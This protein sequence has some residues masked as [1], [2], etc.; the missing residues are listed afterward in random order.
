MSTD[1]PVVDDLD[2]RLAKIRAAGDAP[3]IPVPSIWNP[4]Y[5]L[6]PYQRAGA[7]HLAV[8]KRFVL[9]DPTGSGKTPQELYAW[10]LIRDLRIKS[11][12]HTRLWIVTTKAATKQWEKEVHKFLLDLNVYRLDSG[13]DRER[14]IRQVRE[15]SEDPTCPVLITNW[16]QFSLDWKY[17]KQSLWPWYEED[18]GPLR[19]PQWLTEVQ[20]TLDEAQKIK[21]PAS[22][23]GQTAR[24]ILKYADRAHGLTA[25]LVKNLAQDA[26][27]VVET[28][29]P[30][31]MGS[32]EFQV[33]YC[34]KKPKRFRPRGQSRAIT[35]MEITGYRDLDDFRAKIRDVYL[36]RSDE[37]IEGQR[38]QVRFLKRT[39]R[40]SAAQRTIYLEAEQGIL[41]EEQGAPGAGGIWHAMQAL[42]AP[43]IF[44]DRD[45]YPFSVRTDDNAKMSLLKELLEDE[46]CLK[47]EPIIIYSPLETVISTYY[48]LL[49]EYNPVKVT[50]PE[51]DD[52]RE[53]AR[54]AF[55]EGKTNIILITNAGGEALN[56]QR[57]RHVIMINRP[58]DPGTY[59]QV[60]GR[61]RRFG[62]DNAYITV[63]HLDC[64]DTMDE[65]SDAVLNV[66]FGPVEEIFDGRGQLLPAEQILP[67]D[68]VQYA[69]RRRMRTKTD[70]E[71]DLG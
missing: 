50:G 11:E 17:V 71:T 9:G 28:I 48:R 62:S 30:G 10:G 40:M 49:K 7:A 12:Q 25:T 4:K 59:V 32:Q 51:S 57:A 58:F 23:L 26:Q 3:N 67:K 33:N 36:G 37:E 1:V 21:N 27:A 8:K 24:E 29:C 61:A 66:K 13:W 46:E 19:P 20:V 63:W 53:V 18:D 55:Q 56:L 43:E 44:K 54:E 41:M 45:P 64:E 35:V 5:S 16:A 39:V 70:G 34:I 38:P 65:Y 52:E 31:T 6:V 69:R 42:A 15:W 60:V 22:Q 68:I 2:A 47:D 14:R